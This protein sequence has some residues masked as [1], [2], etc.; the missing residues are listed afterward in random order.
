MTA[1][2]LLEVK[3]HVA[4]VTFNRPDKRNAISYEMW[5]LLGQIVTR[6]E[7]DDSVRCVVFRGAGEAA[8]SSGADINDFR[9]HRYDSRSARKYAEAFEGVQDR[10]ERLPQPTIAMTTG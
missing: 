9:D 3:D 8:F 1:P 5:V 2:V 4:T 6:L 10:V 7:S